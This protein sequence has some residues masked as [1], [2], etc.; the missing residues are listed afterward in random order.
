MFV[1]ALVCLCAAAV[2]GALGAWF[3]TR[4]PSPDYVLRVLRAVAPTSAGFSS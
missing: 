4:P 1:A 3:L 2:T